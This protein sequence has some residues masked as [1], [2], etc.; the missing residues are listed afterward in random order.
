[1]LAGMMARYV[2]TTAL[3]LLCLLGNP[4][5]ELAARQASLATQAIQGRNNDAAKQVL[6]AVSDAFAAAD[7]KTLRQ[8]LNSKVF[9][10]LFTGESGYFSSEQ[11]FF[12]LRNFLSAHVPFSFGFTNTNIGTESAYGVG[13]LRYMKRGHRAAAQVFV[14]LTLSD[15][16]WRINQV[17][18]AQR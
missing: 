9:L 4:S 3:I 10:T 8:Y 13:T 12:I 2:S 15:Q 16:G 11:S 1:M 14:S 5:K 18:I 17:T 6:S 7:T